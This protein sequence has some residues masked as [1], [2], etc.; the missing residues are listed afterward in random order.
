MSPNRL[1]E[2]L[3]LAITIV[4]VV[5]ALVTSA[6]AILH[7]RDP[8]AAVSWSG[9]IWLVPFGGA[10]LY[11]MFGINRLARRAGKLRR[12]RKSIERRNPSGICTQEELCE[13]LT[14][15]AS[16]LGSV[17]KVG[18]KLARKPLLEG[19]RVTMLVNGEQAYPEML[20]AIDEAKRS[21]ALEVY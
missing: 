14:P 4:A 12:R 8:R 16:H 13:A 17:A 9:L 19:N 1:W 5:F 15:G 2:L 11:L 3:P 7:K 21:V 10:M 6:H 20:K 18:D